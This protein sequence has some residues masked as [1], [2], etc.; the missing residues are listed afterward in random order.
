MMRKHQGF[1]HKPIEDFILFYPFLGSPR[2]KTVPG[3]FIENLIFGNIVEDFLSH[4]I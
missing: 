4:S 2:Q 3:L 1:I